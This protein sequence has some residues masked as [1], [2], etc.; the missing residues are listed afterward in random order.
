MG[1]IPTMTSSAGENKLV[2]PARKRAD[3][4]CHSD[5]SNRASEVLLNAISC[6]ECY[7][8]PDQVHAQALRRGMDFVTITDHDS[9]D[10]V[11]KIAD[12]SDV[13][14]GEELTCWFPEDDCKLHV[15][16]WGITAE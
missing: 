5:A 2:P 1:T 10:G 4:H 13:I 14:I 6:P 11:L 12:R 8:R 7:S 15:L 16:L 9:I 3:L